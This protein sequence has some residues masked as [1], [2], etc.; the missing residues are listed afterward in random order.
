[1]VEQLNLLGAVVAVLFFV[2]ASLVF[3]LRLV[4][5]PGAVRWLRYFEYLLA[6]PLIYLLIQA[7]V[8]HRATLYYIQAGFVLFW[9]ALEWVLD[10][11]LRLDFRHTQ[12]VVIT[13]V[14][15][16]FAAAGGLLGI[17]SLAGR[18]WII[19]AGVLFLVMAMLT[20]VQRKVTGE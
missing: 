11:L 12:W 10:D 13:Y 18:G 4:K 19:A 1:M 3:I 2:S 8:V 6:L 14:V 20:F 17:A 7:P 16:F 9:L 15:L 5:R